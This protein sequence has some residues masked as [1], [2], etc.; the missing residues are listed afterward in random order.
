MEGRAPESDLHPI[1]GP[2]SAPHVV[3]LSP[4]SGHGQASSFEGGSVTCTPPAPSQLCP[5]PSSFSHSPQH[6]L[7]QA[8]ELVLTRLRRQVEQRRRQP[9]KL[10]DRMGSGPVETPAS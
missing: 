10:G 8:S 3:V 7:I 9:Q 6:S 1:T 2:V 5:P 4:T